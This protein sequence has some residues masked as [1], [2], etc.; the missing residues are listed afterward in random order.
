VGKSMRD[1]VVHLQELAGSDAD[2][3][4]QVWIFDTLKK[5]TNVINKDTLKAT[6]ALMR[7]LSSRGMT[8]VLLAHTN[9][10]RNADGEY[11]YEGT[12]DLES[13][14]D[15]LI[16]FEP[17]INA[18]GSLTVSTRCTKRRADITEMTWDIH[19][20][21]SVTRR[22]DYVDIGAEAKARGQREKDET[23]VE[24]IT[25]ALSDGPKKQLDIVAFGAAHRITEKAVRAVLK[26]YRGKLW[27]EQRL[28]RDNA[29][30]YRL[31]PVPHPRAEPAEPPNHSSFLKAKDRSGAGSAGS[32][33]SAVRQGAR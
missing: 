9:K 30:E 12:G 20:D 6:L 32:A 22:H 23:A 24:V 29:L 14:S 16:Y 18:D 31:I 1:V 7:K 28:P 17:R 4:G 8:C 19:A 26:R 15:E 10:Y 3:R 33:G 5:L 2:L 25:A 27:L 11:Q 21:R 13:D